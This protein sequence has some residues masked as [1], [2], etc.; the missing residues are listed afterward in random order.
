MKRIL[1]RIR[2]QCLD[3]AVKDTR[4]DGT[5]LFFAFG[6]IEE[7]NSAKRLDVDAFAQT[8]H[9]RGHQSLTRE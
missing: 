3:L 9:G 2:Q 7:S 1:Y 4:N 5:Q 6:M 8:R